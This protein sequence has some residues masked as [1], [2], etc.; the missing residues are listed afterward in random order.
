M[1]GDM[2][3]DGQ[4]DARQCLMRPIGL[5]SGTIYNTFGNL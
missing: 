3:T 1:N 5:G 2:Q 4:T